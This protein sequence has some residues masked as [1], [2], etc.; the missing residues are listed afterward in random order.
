M[1]KKEY[2][3]QLKEYAEALTVPEVAEILR[4]STKTVYK[5]INEK[6]LPAIKVGRGFRVAKSNLIEY[7]RSDPKNSSHPIIF[8]LQKTSDNVWT[9]EPTY[10]IVRCDRKEKTK[11]VMQNGKKNKSACCQ[12]AG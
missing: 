8:S 11:G 5:E 6:K 2:T 9:C 3:T 4:V 7:L 10:G 1:T 12:H